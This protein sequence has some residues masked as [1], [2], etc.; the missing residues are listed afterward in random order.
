MQVGD[1]GQFLANVDVGK[2]G[3]GDVVATIVNAKGEALRES[4]PVRLTGGVVHLLDVLRKN[5]G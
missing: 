5:K 3:A 1:N 2:L 4:I